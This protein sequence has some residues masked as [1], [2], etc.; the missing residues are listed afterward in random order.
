MCL[1][2]KTALSSIKLCSV[3]SDNARVITRQTNAENNDVAIEPLCG[4]RHIMNTA[5]L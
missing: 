3:F 5:M 4:I 1:L 2:D